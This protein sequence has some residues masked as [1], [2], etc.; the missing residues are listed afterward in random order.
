MRHLF[1]SLICALCLNSP[2]AAQDLT[3]LARVTPEGSVISDGWWGR[4]DIT[5]QLSQ[6]V[7][8]RVFTLDDPARL[9][10][11]FREVDFA[12]LTASD[13]LEEGGRIAAIRFGAFQPGWS[14]LVADLSEPM[15]PE[16]IGMPVDPN[17][18]R[19]TLQ[20]ALKTADPEAFAAAS[21]T[22]ADPNWAPAYLDAP[23][24]PKPDD[25]RFTVVLDPGH[26]GIDPGAQNDEINEKNL[27]PGEPRRHRAPR[28]GR[29]LYLIACR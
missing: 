28:G 6:G 2:V 20:I 24:T 18:G 17:T 26:G 15:L 12:G 23:V 25:G 21:G 3:A 8:F 29:Y 27:M 22:P 1:A 9:V 7:P 19:A 5:L 4:S 16:Q 10:V 13:V 11:D 14:R